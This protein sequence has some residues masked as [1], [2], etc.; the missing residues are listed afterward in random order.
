MAWKMKQ[1]RALGNKSWHPLQIEGN[2]PFFIVSAG[3]SGSTLLRRMLCAGQDAHIPPES[4]DFLVNTALSH[5]KTSRLSWLN[6]CAFQA[7]LYAATSLQQFWNISEKE[8]QEYLLSTPVHQQTLYAKIWALHHL[9]KRKFQPAAVRIGDK[10]PLLSEWIPLLHSVSP[11]SKYIYLKRDIRDIIASR[12]KHFEESVDQAFRRCIFSHR[13]IYKSSRIP[14]ISIMSVQYENLVL[15]PEDVMASICRFLDLRFKPEMLEPGFQLVG[16]IS[17][18]HHR[19]VSNP[20]DSANI[21]KWR[22]Q[23]SEQDCSRIGALLRK[24][25]FNESEAY[26]QS[27]V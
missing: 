24:H 14:E 8:Y 16:D 9:H 25:R 18:P 20:I 7:E 6:Q 26:Y 12:M 2:Q 27:T 3:R 23:L 21:G 11:N 22:A 15:K 1:L 17:L 5:L 19:S 4:D 10:T 13:S